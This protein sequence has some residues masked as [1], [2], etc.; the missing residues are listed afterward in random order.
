MLVA[1]S[2]KENLTCIAK[3]LRARFVAKLEEYFSQIPMQLL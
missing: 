3:R 1:A 2:I